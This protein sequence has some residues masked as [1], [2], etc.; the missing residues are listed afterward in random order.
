M[1]ITSAAEMISLFKY[2]PVSMEE[3]IR[4]D[5]KT[6]LSDETDRW[7][8]LFA[9]SQPHRKTIGLDGGIGG[10]L[11]KIEGRIAWQNM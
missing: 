11:Q 4:A 2:L 1:I 7:D 6:G 3:K 5:D 8:H 9:E 10:K